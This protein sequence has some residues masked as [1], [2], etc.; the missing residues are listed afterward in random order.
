MLAESWI[1]FALMT[2]WVAF[3]V[4]RFLIAPPRSEAEDE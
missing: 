1:T 2:G 4:W 3:A